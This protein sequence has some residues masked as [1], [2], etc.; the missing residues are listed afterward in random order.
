MSLGRKNKNNLLDIYLD[1]PR[2]WGVFGFICGLGLV[3]ASLLLL[4]GVNGYSVSILALTAIHENNPVQWIIDTAPIIL[5]ITAYAIGRIVISQKLEMLNLIALQE[6]NVEQISE[7]ADMI[8]KGEFDS[9]IEQLTG[10]GTLVSALINMKS[11]LSAGKQ[12]ELD[13]NWKAVGKERISE[14]LREGKN[15]EEV[16]NQ[17]IYRLVRY[18]DV[19]QGAFY[20]F[21]GKTNGALLKMVASFAYNRKKHLHKQFGVGQGLVG[22]AAFEMDTIHRTE[23]PD[24]YLT[25]TSGIL[26]DRKPSALLFVPLI[27]EDELQGVIELAAFENFTELQIAFVEEIAKMTARTL[28]N[29]SSLETIANTQKRQHALLEKASE[30]ITIYDEDSKV[31]YE[32][33]SV[34]NIL[35]YTPEEMLD[36][37]GFSRVHPKGRADIK[38]MFKHLLDQPKETCELEFSYI[39]KNGERTWLETVG[40]NLLHDPAINGIVLNSR[41][42]T[43]RRIAEKEQIMR[44][45]M[46]SLSENSRNLIIRLDLEGKIVYANPVIEQY[47]GIEKIDFIDRALLETGIN[48]KASESIMK[49][50]D[51][52]KEKQ[53]M[54]ETE[55]DFITV[56]QNLITFVTVIPEND[57]DDRLS[58]ILLVFH[59]ITERK[60]QEILLQETNKKVSESINYAESIQGS[61]L[62]SINAIRRLFPESFVLFKPKDVVSGDFPWMH[63]KGKDLYIAAVD[64]TGHGVPGAMMS[65]VGYFLLNE[66]TGHR[67]ILSPAKVLDHLHKGVVNTLRQDKEDCKNSRDGMDVAL[68][69]IRLNDG[70]DAESPGELQ[71]SGAHRPLYLLR[72]GEIIQYK[73]DSSAVGGV[74]LEKSRGRKRNSNKTREETEKN[75]APFTNH[76][77]QLKHGDSVFFFSDGMPDQFGGE[78]EL[79]YGPKRIRETLAGNGHLEMAQLH[80]LFEEDLVKWMENSNQIDDILMIGIRF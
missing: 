18:I 72:D 78:N 70:S 17:V 5:G 61:I 11:K 27:A 51:E 42:I 10:T 47:T 22:Q 12:S 3:F 39:K 32:S 34:K 21:S 58:S 35:G 63:K 2:K 56:K 4:V 69:K 31:I 46:Q 52:V 1:K 75:K 26:G 38:N 60:N 59:D 14:I 68:C 23:I 29:L 15:V 13:H 74:Q 19:V 44:G 57:A 6:S 53:V 45:K 30:I 24:E 67:E 50:M 8:G 49:L 54:I 73:G 66:I 48:E 28:L 76:S 37:V 43:Q 7:F 16:A 64:C 71:Y 41:D 40:R 77:I 55:M 33:P 65:F 79:K 62:P 36:D 9:D 80:D 25:I 20:K